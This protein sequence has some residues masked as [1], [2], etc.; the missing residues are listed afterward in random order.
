VGAGLLQVGARERASALES[1]RV[2]NIGRDSVRSSV[3]I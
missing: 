2:K 3:M 1:L